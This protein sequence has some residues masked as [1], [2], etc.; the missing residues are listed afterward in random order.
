M[1]SPLKQTDTHTCIGLEE[2][3]GVPHVPFEGLQIGPNKDPQKQFAY[4]KAL[5]A[6]GGDVWSAGAGL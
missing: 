6:V 1:L 4:E 2:M 3:S 5:H